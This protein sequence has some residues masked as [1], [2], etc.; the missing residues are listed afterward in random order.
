MPGTS[1]HQ[2]VNGVCTAG[3]RK[4]GTVITAHPACVRRPPAGGTVTL[5]PPRR[6]SLRG[7][8]GTRT[9]GSQRRASR[10]SHRRGVRRLGELYLGQQLPPSAGPSQCRCRPTDLRWLRH[11]AQLTWVLPLTNL[12]VPGPVNHGQTRPIYLTK[13][14]RAAAR[15]VRGGVP[16]GREAAAGRRGRP[17]RRAP[18]AGLGAAGRCRAGCGPWVAALPLVAGGWLRSPRLC[19][20]A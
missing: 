14:G 19:K 15:D 18:D 17:Q 11:Q 3:G 4:R 1:R 10:A 6:A 16:P 5:P 7:P 8:K 2:R 12:H 20:L 13:Q 9:S